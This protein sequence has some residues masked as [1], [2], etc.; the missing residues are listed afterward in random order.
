[1]RIRICSK[2]IYKTINLMATNDA[3]ENFLFIFL[4]F[5]SSQNCYSKWNRALRKEIIQQQ[6]CH[7]AQKKRVEF[8]F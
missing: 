4:Y 3:A 5:H 6:K 2:K 7:L 1:M 8:E